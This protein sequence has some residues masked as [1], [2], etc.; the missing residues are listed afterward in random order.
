MDPPRAGLTSLPLVPWFGVPYKRLPKSWRLRKS[1]RVG[2]YFQILS[3]PWVEMDSMFPIIS[4]ACV[5]HT[6]SKTALSDRLA[7]ILAEEYFL[8]PDFSLSIVNGWTSLK[9]PP[10]LLPSFFPAIYLFTYYLS[11]KALSCGWCCISVY[12]SARSSLQKKQ[13]DPYCSTHRSAG[14]PE[15]VQCCHPDKPYTRAIQWCR[16]TAKFQRWRVLSLFGVVFFPVF[17]IGARN[18]RTPST[19]PDFAQHNMDIFS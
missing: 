6:D 9:H 8:T 18:T 10:S 3:F 14:Q 5:D 2:C 19:N 13:S 11:S 7:W 17:S 12:R 1:T 15:W 16:L 4:W